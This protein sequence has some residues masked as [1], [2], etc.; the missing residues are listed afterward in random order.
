MKGKIKYMVFSL[1]LAVTI[2]ILPGCDK[3]TENRIKIMTSTS[4]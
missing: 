3:A 1:L 2:L 4:L